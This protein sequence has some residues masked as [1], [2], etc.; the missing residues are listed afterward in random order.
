MLLIS[1]GFCVT[2]SAQAVQFSSTQDAAKAEIRGTAIP[3][4]PGASE[5]EAGAPS[6]GTPPDAPEPMP[7]NGGGE[8]RGN[9]PW[10]AEEHQ[11]PFSRVGVGADLSPLGIGIKSAVVLTEYL[12]ARAVTSFFNFDSGIFELEGFRADARLHLA[13]AGGMVDYYP[14]NSVWR[15]SGGLMLFNGNQLTAKTD[16]VPGTSFQLNNETFYS[17]NANSATGATPLTGTGVLGMHRHLPAFMASFG[18]GKFIP[19]S[20]RHWSFPSE[21]G[22]VFTGAPT[23]NTTTSGWVCTDAAQSQ[24]SNISNPANPVAVQFNNALQAQLDKWR[25]SLSVVTVYPILSYS[26]MYSFNIR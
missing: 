11:Q 12:D 5:D 15:L 10:A 8:R 13:S 25:K 23:I 17:A 3:L 24:C 9:V 2:V 7:F 16:I 14:L 18:F 21:F 22:L 1:P 19:R 26:V 6:A 4:A 20:N